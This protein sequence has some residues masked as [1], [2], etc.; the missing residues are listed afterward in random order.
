MNKHFDVIRD[1]PR[2]KGK[3]PRLVRKFA[4]V[5]HESPLISNRGAFGRMGQNEWNFAG[6][7]KRRLSMHSK[8][9]VIPVF[10]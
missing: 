3:I 1:H 6:F 10:L 7:S 2:A 5:L 4:I 9:A 8:L